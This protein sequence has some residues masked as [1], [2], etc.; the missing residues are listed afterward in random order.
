MSDIDWAASSRGGGRG[1]VTG[2]RARTR[3]SVWVPPGS[4]TTGGSSRPATS[5]TLS[6]GLTLCAE[7]GLVSAFARGRRRTPDRRR[8]PHRARRS[9]HAVR[10][11]PPAAVGGRWRRRCWSTATARCGRC[12]RSCRVRSMPIVWRRA[13][14]RRRHHQGQARWRTADVTSSCGG[15]S[16][17]TPRA[18]WPTSRPL[19][20]AWR[21]SS[22][23]CSPASS[24]CGPR[25]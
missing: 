25:R 19:R 10:S 22:R 21:S 12:L 4:S 15:S 17:R 2:V 16:T 5:R 11:L 8:D 13:D 23:G 1:C 24:R 7:C 14:E 3:S 9:G 6:Y 20:C 18:R